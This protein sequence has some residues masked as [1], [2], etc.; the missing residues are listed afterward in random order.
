MVSLRK[1][2]SACP[3]VQRR[4]VGPRELVSPQDFVSRVS[5]FPAGAARNAS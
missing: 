1:I 2:Y 3:E 4:A 5:L